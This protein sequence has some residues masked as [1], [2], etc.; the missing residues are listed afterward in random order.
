MVGSYT[1]ANSASELN[2]LIQSNTYVL[3]DFWATWCP[4]CKMI[5]PIFEKLASEHASEGNVA[6]VKVDVDAQQEIAQKYQITAM[7]TF[8]FIKDGEIQQTVRG[9]NPPALKAMAQIA[10]EATKNAKK[11]EPKQEA[12]ADEE[13]V[14]G[15]YGLSQGAKSHW[16]MSLN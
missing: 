5:A 14:S 8:L 12:K 11:P 15:Q 1:I 13:T 6:F 9:A 16:K 7:P 10:T 2:K 4:P 3:I